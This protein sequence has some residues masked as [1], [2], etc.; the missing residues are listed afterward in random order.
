MIILDSSFIIAF[1]VESDQN[2]ERAVKIMSEI[3]SGKFDEA[4]I[5]DYIFDEVITV[6]FGRTKNLDKV[7]FIGD[8]LRE[9]LV[10]LR[11]NEEIFEEAWKIFKSQKNTTL[12]FTDCSIIALMKMKSISNLATFDK[13][14]KKVSGINVIS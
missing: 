3:N 2:H 6:S 7:V 10:F 1:E 13:D 12:S 11:I 8:K 5:S 9:S 4:I 14:F